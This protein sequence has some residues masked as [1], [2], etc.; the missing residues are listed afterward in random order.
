V[1][2]LPTRSFLTILIKQAPGVV[3]KP[4]CFSLQHQLAF[5]RSLSIYC[6][7]PVGV[8]IPSRHIFWEFAPPRYSWRPPPFLRPLPVTGS[9]GPSSLSPLLL[10]NHRP[11]ALNGLSRLIHLPF[12]VLFQALAMVVA[13]LLPLL[14]VS[15]FSLILLGRLAF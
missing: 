2:V 3:C 10:G 13:F 1:V 11:L 15:F 4:V 8:S 7:L 12:F 5:F 9:T 6:N 14:P